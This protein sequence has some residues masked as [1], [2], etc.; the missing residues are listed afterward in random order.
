MKTS[1]K[2]PWLVHAIAQCSDCD[3]EE[4]SYRIAVKQGR[5]HA[6]K[7][8]HEVIVETGYAQIYNSKDKEKNNV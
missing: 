3:W 4:M 6:R 2:G 7:T 5:E 1:S 8:G